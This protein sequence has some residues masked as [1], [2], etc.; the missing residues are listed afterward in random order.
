MFVSCAGNH[1]DK[2]NRR[3]QATFSC[4]QCGFSGLADHIAA[5]NISSRAL[6][7]VPNVSDAEIDFY[8][9]APGTSSPALAGSN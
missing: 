5:G 2:A 6:L 9:A 4:V 3:T 1:I 8:S 7:S